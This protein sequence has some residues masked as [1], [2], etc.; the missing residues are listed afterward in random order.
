VLIGESYWKAVVNSI[1]ISTSTTIAVIVLAVPAGYAF[2]RYRFRGDNIL[3]IGVLFL[4]LFP[5]IGPIVPYYQIMSWLGLLNSLP[6]SSSP[7]STCGC[8]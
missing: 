8:R 3:F 7:R 6:G 1:I 2:S 4:R 5:P